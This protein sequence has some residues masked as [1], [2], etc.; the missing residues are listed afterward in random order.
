MAPRAAPSTTAGHLNDAER[1]FDAQLAAAAAACHGVFGLNE[2]VALGITPRSVQRRVHAARLHRVHRSVYSV[3]PSGLL[4]VSGRYRAAVLACDGVRAAALSHRSAADLHGLRACHRRT[5][6]VLVPGRTTHRHPGIQVHRS[7]NLVAG[8]ADVTLVDA[9]P[10]TTVART[11]LDLAA[12]V[13]GR[14]V[15]RALSQAEVLRILDV[16][17]LTAQ[18]D[19]NPRHP[20]AGRIMA[21]LDRHRSGSTVGESDLEVLF[22]GLCDTY[23][24]PRPES[25]ASV[26]PGDGGLLFRPD[27]VWRTQR[28]AVECDSARFHL[29]RRAFEADRHRDQRLVAAGWRVVRVTWRQLTERP[30]GVAETLRQVLAAS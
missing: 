7:V 5:V 17:A 27:C 8:D 20:G 11:L 13:P 14:A 30:A 22:A 19:R 25:N 2:L 1:R 28:V 9:V 4:T 18:L 10:V 21:T 15:E 6:E 12:V 16:A 26:D 24:L 29:T 23:D 3:V